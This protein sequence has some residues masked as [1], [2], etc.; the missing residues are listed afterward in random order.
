MSLHASAAVVGERGVLFRGASGSGK[1]SLALA[2]LDLARAGGRFGA[3]VGDDRVALQV[4]HG[5]LVAQGVAATAGL[6]E[7]RGLGIV[8]APALARCVIVLVADCDASPHPPARAPEAE[9]LQ[10]LIEGIRLPR[11][12]L[13]HAIAV[14]DG[15]RM[16]LNCLD[17]FRVNSGL[18]QDS[19]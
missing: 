3:L 7:M 5:R 2:L 17:R 9:E 16:V 8:R 18:F 6:A 13:T 12:H 14:Q 19:P 4:R 1:S 11:L 15:A 10:A